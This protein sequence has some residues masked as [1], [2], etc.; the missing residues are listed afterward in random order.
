VLV[1]RDGG[2]AW[3]DPG[4]REVDAAGPVEDAAGEAVDGEGDV[5][6]AGPPAKATLFR[7][8][9]VEIAPPSTVPPSPPG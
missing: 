1:A 7:A 8:P 4:P 9:A 6:D 3:V 2:L 5:A